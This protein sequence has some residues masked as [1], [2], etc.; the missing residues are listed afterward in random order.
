MKSLKA[1]NKNSLVERRSSSSGLIP[2]SDFF[3]QKKEDKMKQENNQR[4]KSR[5]DLDLYSAISNKTAPT[6]DG[7]FVSFADE[8]KFASKIQEN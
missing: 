1:T 5:L 2:N 4:M 7:H 8:Y 3:K 6:K